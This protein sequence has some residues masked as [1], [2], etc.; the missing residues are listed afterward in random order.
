MRCLGN[1]DPVIPLTVL[2]L[3][4]SLGLFFE[5]EP[6]TVAVHL[7][8]FKL[9]VVLVAI[10]PEASAFSL[11]FAKVEVAFVPGPVVEGHYSFT[12]HVVVAEF[13]FVQLA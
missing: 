10:V 13:S 2:P 7:V 8:V 11:H 5:V 9:A 1:A 6:Q 3:P 4:L 12:L